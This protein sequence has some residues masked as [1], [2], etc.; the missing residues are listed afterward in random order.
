[1]KPAAFEYFRPGSLREALELA[2]RH[3]DDQKLLAGGQSLVPLMNMRLAQVDNVVDL[4]GV[5]ELDYL[6]EDATFL[7]CGAMTRQR[8]LERSAEVRERLPLLWHALG[9]VG[10][11]QIRNR[12]T[13]G[14]SIAHADPAAELPAV[15]LALDGELQVERAGSA[16]VVPA[17]EFFLSYFTTALAADEIL[18]EVRFRKLPAGSGWS[19]QEVARRHGD[20]ALVALAARLTFRAGRVDEARIVVAGAADRPVRAR[21]AE[22]ALL[23]READGEAVAAA[24]AL[25]EDG[26]EPSGDVHASAGY[27]RQAAGVLAR[28][29]LRE[30]A[31]RAG[32]A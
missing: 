24:A 26:I 19:F 11:F 15:L 23:G 31:E 28:R 3:G 18:T 29:A 4:N 22:D 10:H 12:G 7:R 21:E 25:V 30:C 8:T 20:F 9:H 32:P 2:G 1:V 27:R 5:R 17:G 13:V 6:R 14:G 16:R